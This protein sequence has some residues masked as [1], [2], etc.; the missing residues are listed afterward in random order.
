MISN[1]NGLGAA[2]ASPAGLDALTAYGDAIGLAF[3]ITDDVLDATSTTA[4]LGKTA[5]R[6][7]ELRKST[8]PML[9]G[10]ERA[11]ARAD[12]LVDDACAALERA[13]LRTATL[14]MLARYAIARTS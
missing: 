14:D 4:A 7:V 3:Q 5:G 13:G 9:L 6:D 2:G 11:V 1:V 12:S 8:Y 10:I